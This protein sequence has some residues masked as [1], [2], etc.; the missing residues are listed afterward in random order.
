M[1]EKALLKRMAVKLSEIGL[2]S[3]V[4]DVIGSSFIFIYQDDREGVSDNVVLGGEVTG[5]RFVEGAPMP[6]FLEVVG[7]HSFSDYRVEG[8]GFFEGKWQMFLDVYDYNTKLDNEVVGMEFR[9]K[10]PV[11][12]RQKEAAKRYLEQAGT[13][14]E[15]MVAG[16]FRLV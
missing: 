5:L 2:P 9:F 12:E 10:N 11:D 15:G 7:L 8:F 13:K 3:S 16:T 4:G 6:V 1:E 14:A